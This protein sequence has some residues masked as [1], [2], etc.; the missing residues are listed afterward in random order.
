MKKKIIILGST[1]SIGKNTFNLIKKDRKNFE[2]K[3]LSTNK[4]ISEIIKQAKTFKVKDLI[5]SDYNKYIL[6][7]KYK[8]LRINFHNSFSVIDKLFKKKEIFYSMMSL[9][10]LDGLK[11]TL[12]LIRYSQNIAIVNKESLICGW[13][14]IK[15][16]KKNKTNFIPVDSEH[17]SIFSLIEKNP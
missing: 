14:L 5:I 10:G 2:I 3:L 8:N 7:K 17:Y 6:A 11:P 1:G 16:T 13:T 9:V 12:Q 15:K 4:N